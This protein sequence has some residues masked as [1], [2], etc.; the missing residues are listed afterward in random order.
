M[1]NKERFI[2]AIARYQNFHSHIETRNKLLE[3]AFGSDTT[4]FNF[5][6]LDEIFNTIVDMASFIF[7]NLEEKEIE[8]WL[9]W[10]IYEASDMDKPEVESGSKTYIISNSEEL[11]NM[12]YEFN[13]EKNESI[14]INYEYVNDSYILKSIMKIDW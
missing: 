13:E 10:Y 2:R 3:K 4:I 8:D 14:S 7:P 6:G 5:D 12:L 11:Y 1:E 9:G